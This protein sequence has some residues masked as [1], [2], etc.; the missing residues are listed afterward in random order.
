MKRC[1]DGCKY[2]RIT[3][4]TEKSPHTRRLLL[5][6]HRLIQPFPKT[7]HKLLSSLRIKL[8]QELANQNHVLQ[9]AR[10]I[11]NVNELKSDFLKTFAV[12]KYPMTNIEDSSLIKLT[13]YSQKRHDCVSIRA[14]SIKDLLYRII[15]GFLLGRNDSLNGSNGFG[16]V[17]PSLYE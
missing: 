7:G 12:L 17:H 2:I 16:H 8:T 11:G 13:Q 1:G 3:E 10:Y 9:H 5:L 15:L 4:L 6:L 14:K